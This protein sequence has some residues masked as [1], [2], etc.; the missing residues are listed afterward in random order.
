MKKPLIGVAPLFDTAKDSVWMLPFYPDGIADAG[1]IPII[2]PLNL[3][4][5]DILQ[6][7]E[8][9]DG[10]LF[11]GGQDVSPLLYGEETRASC[12]EVCAQRDVLE[13]ALIAAALQ[14][15][16]PIFGICRGIQILNAALGGTLYQDLTERSGNG[17]PLHMQKSRYDAKAHTVEILPGTLL[18]DIVT[19]DRTAVNSFHHQGI[20]DLSPRLKP[21]AVSSDGLVEAAYLPDQK[22]ALAVQWH[23]EYLWGSEPDSAA[24]F[25]A[26]VNVCTDKG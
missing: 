18:H 19:K 6:L 14:A 24:L 13:T 1:G 15:G 4:S 2:L 12:G 23:P 22:F 25:S 3:K 20:K 26:F 10:F 17:T 11:T 9:F 5:G 21:A 16:K 8:D 7:A